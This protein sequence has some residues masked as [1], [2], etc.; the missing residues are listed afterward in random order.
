MLNVIYV[1]LMNQ[2][3]TILLLPSSSLLV[4]NVVFISF[5]IHPSRNGANLLGNWLRGV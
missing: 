1:I 4:W 2:Y 5:G 3:N